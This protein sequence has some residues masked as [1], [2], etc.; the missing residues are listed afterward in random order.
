MSACFLACD[1]GVESGR[2]MLGK[3]SGNFI[4]LEEVFR[5]PN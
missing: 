3:L 2:L 1:L 5:F 4:E